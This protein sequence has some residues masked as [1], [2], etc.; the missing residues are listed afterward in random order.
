MAHAIVRLHTIQFSRT[1]PKLLAYAAE[2]AYARLPTRAED[3]S[4]ISVAVKPALVGQRL[5]R[6]GAETLELSGSAGQHLFFVV[7][8]FFCALSRA[9]NTA[10][11]FL[12]ESARVNQLSS[13]DLDRA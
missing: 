2:A 3:T 9:A 4:S 8:F 12:E 6:R 13:A 1:E 10:I 5:L 11:P 7:V